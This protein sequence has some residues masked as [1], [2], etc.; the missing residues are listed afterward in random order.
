M[1]AY[2][3]DTNLYVKADREPEAANELTAFYRSHLASTYLHA[4]VVLEILA[5]G[6]TRA[7]SRR[8]QD[9]YVTPFEMRRRLV[10]PSFTSYKRAGEVIGRLRS[11]SVLT[12]GGVPRSF[13]NDV[14][15]AVSC[16]ELGLTLVTTNVRDFER[17]RE[18]LDFDFVP[19]W[20]AA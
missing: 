19:P 10:T 18:V 13:T 11:R 15:L 5:G 7:T 2:V 17:I 12:A 1:T 14:L 3:L 16:R 20:P 9:Q 6:V 8:L 4:V